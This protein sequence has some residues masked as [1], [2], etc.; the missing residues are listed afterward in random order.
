MSDPSDSPK[1]TNRLIDET[2]PYLLQH[3]HNPVDWYPWGEE[4]LSKAR[5]ERR[6]ILLS[7]GYSSCHW[8]HVM[9]R[10]SFENEEIARLMNE[11]F[12]SI[13]VDREER[14]DLD[15]IYM[16][17]TLAMN[18]GQGGWPMTV[19]LTPDLEPAFAGTYFPPE[20]RYGQ[21]GFPTLL[22][23]IA[24]TWEEDPDGIRTGA[25][26][27]TAQ[28]R[29][30]RQGNTPLSVGEAELKL[31]LSQFGDDF[32]STFGGFG[33]APKFPPSTGLSLLMR[34]HRRFDDGHALEMVCKTLDAMRNG[35]MHD[36]IGGGF[37]RYSTDRQWL[38]PHFEKMLY[39]NALLTGAYIEAYQLTGEDKYRDTATE[40][41]DYVAREMTLPEGGFYSATD[42][43]SEGVEGKFFVWTPQEIEEILGSHDAKLFNAYY[44][45]AEGGNW[46]G[47]SIPNTP[48]PL[49]DLAVQF[50]Q[51]PETLRRLLD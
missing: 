26:R 37:S 49:A 22:Q 50:D 16:A 11:H 43:D 17:A 9:E 14:P 7:I 20:D 31:A 34:L 5:E 28:L 41:L 4:A 6:L 45:I 3:A 39:D 19:F 24:Q 1:Y 21:P 35:G 48:R 12:V 51:A 33:T 18:H 32:D 8:C 40:T 23:R 36:H 42:A 13:K 30:Q 2:S 10:E 25:A 27:F 15:D 44:D 38:V 29:A 47:K 46:E